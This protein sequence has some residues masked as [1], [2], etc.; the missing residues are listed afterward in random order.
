MGNFTM[1]VFSVNELMNWTQQADLA[2][3]WCWIKEQS[4]DLCQKKLKPPLVNARDIQ[5]FEVEI[6]QGDSPSSEWTRCRMCS[7]LVGLSSCVVDHVTAIFRLKKAA[8]RFGLGEQS[9]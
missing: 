3:V 5:T 4:S 9:I 7:V 2:L 8:T 6:P 1:L